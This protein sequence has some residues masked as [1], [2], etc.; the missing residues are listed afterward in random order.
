MIFYLLSKAL[1]LLI[2]PLGL[3]IILILV[4]INRRYRWTLN[5]AISILFL[6]SSGIVSKLLWSFIESPWERLSHERVPNVEAIVVLS[7]GQRLAPGK[8]K[9]IEW[10]DPDRFFAGVDLYKAGKSSKLFFTGGFNPN[11]PELELEG[12]LYRRKAI[13]LGV[14]YKNIALTGRVKNTSEEA[15][16]INQLITNKYIANKPKIILV[17]SAFHMTRAKKTFEREGLE[18]F[19]FPVDFQTNKVIDSNYLKN[20]LNWIPNARNLHASSTAIR[21]LYGRIFYRTWD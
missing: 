8:A 12:N 3:S 11:N 15:N 7:G 16:A 21:E 18:V 4:H 10:N 13:E 1:P 14:P 5:I 2:L 19:P 17:T 9:I 6:F 20:P